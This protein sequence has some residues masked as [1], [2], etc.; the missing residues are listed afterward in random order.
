MNLQK[1]VEHLGQI[2]PLEK[3]DAGEFAHCKVKMMHS[4]LSCYSLEDWGT[5]SVLEAKGMGGLMQR[6]LLVINSLHKDIPVFTVQY[7]ALWGRHLLEI[8]VLDIMKDKTNTAHFAGLQGLFEAPG[9]KKQEMPEEWYT[10]MQMPGSGRKKGSAAAMEQCIESMVTAFVKAAKKVRLTSAVESR[11]Q[12]QRR[13]MEQLY[14]HGGFSYDAY[15]VCMKQ[16]KTEEMFNRWV[17]CVEA[18]ENEKSIEPPVERETEN[19]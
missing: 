8:N 18:P 2:V 19:G 16:A 4:T 3:C 14:D 7:M 17:F 5:V 11:L 15:R 1:I 6:S 12:R 9:L 10:S 13:M